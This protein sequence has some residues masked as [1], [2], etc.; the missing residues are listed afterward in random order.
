M[1]TSHYVQWQSNLGYCDHALDWPH[2]FMSSQH[3]SVFCKALHQ[4]KH[5]CC[6][7]ETA[8]WAVTGK[9]FSKTKRCGQSRAFCK[10]LHQQKHLCCLD[11]TAGWAVTGKSFSKTQN[12]ISMFLTFPTDS[13]PNQN[14]CREKSFLSF[15]CKDTAFRFATQ[16]TGPSMQWS[17]DSRLVWQA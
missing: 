8:G 16:A 7:D 4:Q 3:F 13:C 14:L 12:L 1:R 10:V 11:E 17:A 6:L 2:R 15:F 9:S 5:L